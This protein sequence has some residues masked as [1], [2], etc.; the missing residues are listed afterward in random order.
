MLL[1]LGGDSVLNT[2]SDAPWL[3]LYPRNTSGVRWRWVRGSDT[4]LFP[5]PIQRSALAFSLTSG[6]YNVSNAVRSLELLSVA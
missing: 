6:D 5:P 1:K 4:A 3:C 2:G